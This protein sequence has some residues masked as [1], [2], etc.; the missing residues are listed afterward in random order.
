MLCLSGSKEKLSDFFHSTALERNPVCES[1]VEVPL[2]THIGRSYR[3]SGALQPPPPNVYRSSRLDG[4]Q[5]A[6]FRIYR[7]G[8]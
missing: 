1:Q 6:I 8:V 2:L 3:L 4:R 5:G 7:T